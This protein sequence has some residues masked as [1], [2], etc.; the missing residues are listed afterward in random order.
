MKS[1]QTKVVFKGTKQLKQHLTIFLRNHT[2]YGLKRR[3]RGPI[4]RWLKSEAKLFIASQIIE[5][6]GNHRTSVY[7]NS[8]TVDFNCFSMTSNFWRLPVPVISFLPLNKDW[9][10]FLVT[11]FRIMLAGLLRFVRTCDFD[12]ISFSNESFICARQGENFT[13]G[14]F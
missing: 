10:S 11:S 6:A 3:G 13:N 7:K 9:T 8:N 4:V 12:I 1:Q 2:A 5:N 14:Y